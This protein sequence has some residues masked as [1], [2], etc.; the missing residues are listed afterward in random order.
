MEALCV[1]VCTLMGNSS[2]SEF[3]MP[4]FGPLYLFHLHRSMKMERTECSETSAYKIQK[5]GD[6]PEESI[7]H[8]E[9]DKSLKSRVHCV[10]SVGWENFKFH[11]FII[12][13]VTIFPSFIKYSNYQ[14]TFY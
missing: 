9:Q 4:R 12:Y 2:A 14:V 8:S 10:F 13:I 7:Q 3:Y 11:D 5:S 6:Y 1:V